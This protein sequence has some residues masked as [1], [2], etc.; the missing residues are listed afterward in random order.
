MKGW[1]AIRNVFILIFKGTA[2]RNVFPYT[3]WVGSMS[4]WNSPKFITILK[5]FN[6]FDVCVMK[7]L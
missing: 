2:L 6:D 3:D 4:K 7:T 1:A 5:H